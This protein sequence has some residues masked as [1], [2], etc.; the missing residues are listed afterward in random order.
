MFD[1]LLWT[2]VICVVP[3][4]MAVLGLAMSGSREDARVDVTPRFTYTFVRH[5]PRT[6]A[7]SHVR[8]VE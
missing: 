2:M 8:A 5:T 3:V 1:F 4:I 7:R 6:R